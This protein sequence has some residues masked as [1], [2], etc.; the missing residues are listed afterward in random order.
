M[1]CVNFHNYGFVHERIPNELKQKLLYEAE[2]NN[3]E[4][5]ESGVSGENI[6]KHKWLKHNI[7]PLKSYVLN[8]LNAY[9][10]VYP[11]LNELNYH[12]GSLPLNFDTPWIN[13]QK[14]GEYIPYHKHDGIYSYNIWLKIPTNCVF[15]FTYTNILGNI[16]RHDIN[17][18]KED[19]GS[20]IMFPAK[21]PH[22]VYP[23]KN[24]EDTRI[25]I[26]GNISF[27]APNGTSSNL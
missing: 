2:N 23:F 26:A 7:D 16:E 21:L 19:E 15:Q 6:T 14:S 27:Q 10:I 18:H 8:V 11:R 4:E 17:L 25:S 5:F 1:P 3:S 12:N 13:Y 24:C 9:N 20:I 22:V